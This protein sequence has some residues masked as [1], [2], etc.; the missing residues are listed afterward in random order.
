VTE[1]GRLPARGDPW[2]LVTGVWMVVTAVG[3]V[4]PPLGPHGFQ[5]GGA[6]YHLVGFSVLTV[7]FSRRLPPW[8]AAAAAWLYGLA[9]EGV[10]GFLPHRSA[11]LADLLVNLVAVTVGLVAVAVW[12]VRTDR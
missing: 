1:P 7:L 2:G 12:R 10:Q 8:R 3:G 9:L 5:P 4:L 6:G 11:E